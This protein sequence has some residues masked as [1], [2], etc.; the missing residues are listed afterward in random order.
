[1]FEKVLLRLTLPDQCRSL[2]H[3]Q[4]QGC[5]RIF[6]L[7]ENTWL[8]Y[9]IGTINTNQVCQAKNTIQTHQI[10]SGDMVTVKPGCYIGTM[11]HIISADESEMIEIQKKTMDWTE[12]WLNSSAGPTLRASTLPFKAPG[13]R[14][15]E[16][17]MLVSQF[18]ELDQ[19]PTSRDALDFH[20]TSSHDWDRPG[21]PPD[22]RR[23]PTNCPYWNQYPHP[24]GHTT[25]GLF[26]TQVQ[27]QPPYEWTN[28]LFALY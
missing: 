17:S 10:N 22:W 6:E 23:I 1:M 19:N 7:A 2:N 24:T 5:R 16:S 27:L 21:Q 15:T 13:Q 14:T 9:S 8:V 4:I 20:L 11:D 18:K 25:P 26:T 28:T 12:N 3:M